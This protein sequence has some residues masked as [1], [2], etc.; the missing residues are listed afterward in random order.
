M[1]TNAA[2]MY[3]DLPAI[4]TPAPFNAMMCIDSDDRAIVVGVTPAADAGPP[5]VRL[6]EVSIRS[7]RPLYEGDIELSSP[8]SRTDLILLGMVMAMVLGMVAVT[9]VNPAEPAIALPEGASLAEAPRRF[10]A[11]AVDVSIGLVVAMRITRVDMGEAL[12][13]GWWGSAEAYLCVIVAM[14]VLIVYGTLLERATGRTV[15]KALTG[16]EVVDARAAAQ[17]PGVDRGPRPTLLRC[18]VR[19]AVKWGLPPIGLLGIF[20]A[21]G[22]HRADQIART[23]VIIREPAD[24]AEE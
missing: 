6:T 21:D 10:F 5:K 23:A 17:T 4:K 12:N 14:G 22:R 11:G 8:V 24:E 3:T 20:A 18:L 15:G 2:G 9:V 16:C 7:G 13:A 19:N 1:P